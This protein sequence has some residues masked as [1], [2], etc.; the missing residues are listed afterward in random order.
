MQACR[1]LPKKLLKRRK[2]DSVSPEAAITGHGQPMMGQELKD[3]L[4]KLANNFDEIA[5]PDSGKY[6]E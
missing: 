1:N 5:K 4:S 6:T 2:N 3:E